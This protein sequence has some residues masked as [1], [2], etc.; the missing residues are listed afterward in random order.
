MQYNVNDFLL[1]DE[2]SLYKIKT[3]YFVNEPFCFFVIT[4]IDY[5]LLVPSKFF[6]KKNYGSIFFSG[7]ISD[8]EYFEKVNEN[9]NE[10]TFLFIYKTYI[11]CKTFSY[12]VTIN[13]SE[14][15]EVISLF[16][17]KNTQINNNISM[18]IP[19]NVK[20]KEYIIEK[21]DMESMENLGN[22]LK[23][24]YKEHKDNNFFGVLVLKELYKFVYELLKENGDE[25]GAKIYLSKIEKIND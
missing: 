25:Q 2:H 9:E 23:N 6:N 24:Y 17:Q 13:K 22:A 12:K 20:L 3:D 15:Y 8:I 14:Y 11:K 21:E 4:E 1:N 7:L 16:K 18:I 19:T 10:I 5:L